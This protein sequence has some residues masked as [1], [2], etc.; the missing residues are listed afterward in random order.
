MCNWFLENE[1]KPKSRVEIILEEV[2]KAYGTTPDTMYD[3]HKERTGTSPG[4]RQVYFFLCRKFTV[5]TPH[6]I[7]EPLKKDR[8][9]VLHAIKTI[10]GYIE[11]NAE[12]K[13]KV[14]YIE[15]NIRQR[16]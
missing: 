12:F 5:L 15:Y 7:G 1:D 4:E 10:K 16:L 6:V 14:D 11:T 3:C 13:S 8:A 9:T 2:A